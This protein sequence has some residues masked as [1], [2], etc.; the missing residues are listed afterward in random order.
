MSDKYII[1]LIIQSKIIKFILNDI[2]SYQPFWVRLLR[3][4]DKNKN[5]LLMTLKNQSPKKL[6]EIVF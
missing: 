5:N 4:F 6:L 1:D 2:S 3:N